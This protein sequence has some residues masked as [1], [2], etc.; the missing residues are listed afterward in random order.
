MANSNLKTLSEIFNDKI[1][2]IPDYQRG[3]SWGESQLEDLWRDIDNLP[4]NK[5]HYTGM[6]TVDIQ[7]NK[8]YHVIDGQQRL[9]SLI[10]FLKNILDKYNEEWITEDLEKNEAIKKYLYAK[11]KNSKNPKIIFG[12]YEN[13]SSYYY[14]K[15]QILDIE[16]KTNKNHEL[17]LYTDNLNF[18]NNFFQN[19]LINKT[20]EELEELFLRLTNQLKFNWYEI[21]KT[22]D[23]DEYVIFETMN[24]RG[25][26]LSVLEILKNRLIYITTLLDNDDS[27]KNKLRNDINDVWKTIFEYLGKDKKMDEDWFLKHHIVMYWGNA[28]DKK[29]DFHKSYLL[30]HFFTIQKIFNKNINNFKKAHKLS[31]ELK[32]IIKNLTSSK[33]K[34]SFIKLL[35][36]EFEIKH[37]FH[38]NLQYY[39][40]DYTV[41]END[42]MKL[43]AEKYWK[44]HLIEGEY[45]NNGKPSG[46]N[47]KRSKDDLD[48]HIGLLQLRINRA[49]NIIDN[50]HIHYDLIESYISSL[51]DSIK[52]YYFI[53][54]PKK[55]NYDSKIICW[56]EKNNILGISEFMPILLSMFNHYD[57]KDE[58]F[59]I[60]ILKDIENY[61]FVKKYCFTKGQQWL[62]RNF[63]NLASQYNKDQN[64]QIF[65]DELHTLIY[66]KN[67]VKN[68]DKDN[69]ILKIKKLFENEDA[70]GY[71]GWTEGL[72]YVLYEYEISLQKQYHGESKIS[73]KDI[74]KESI[75]HIYP[76]TPKD[77]WI[78]AFSNLKSTKQ[79]NKYT[80]FLGNLLLLSSKKNSQGS[81]KPFK[82]KKEIFSAGSFNEIEVSK[83]EKWTT[84]EIDER[85]E[86]ILE[87]MNERW[88]LGLR[89]A[90]IAKLK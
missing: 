32:D 79:R 23:L 6:I 7:D 86:K 75:E 39:N 46:T 38:N 78:D 4:L 74:N 44:S 62:N 49:V 26:P 9:T 27:D 85:S 60:Q 89:I 70:K 80:H 19:K 20:Q 64:I 69:F 59:I 63:Y 16:D 2:K 71:Y 13:N 21:E 34:N 31:H 8:T 61:L 28:F 45:F 66:D 58:I 14:Y 90:D 15:T 50:N 24:N 12:Y 88:H 40:N 53:F 41:I 30:T 22:D 57:I 47:I 43:T 54:N 51:K 84:K 77:T 76:Q 11:T 29:E 36:R 72:K 87:F 65:S 35:S 25:K 56:L 73:W 83:Y 52:S 5:S 17:T 33:N 68:F 10:I 55:S 67:I 82:D 42:N 1:F 37:W 81:N 3:Y 18:S 48:L